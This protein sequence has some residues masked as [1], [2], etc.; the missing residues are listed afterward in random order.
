MSLVRSQHGPFLASAGRQDVLELVVP[1]GVSVGGRR[2]LEQA[3]VGAANETDAHDQGVSRVSRPIGHHNP[4]RVRRLAFRG[5]RHA[6]V[7]RAQPVHDDHRGGGQ[8]D[9]RRQASEN[10]TQPLCNTRWSQSHPHTEAWLQASHES[11]SEHAPGRAQPPG[12]QSRVG[13][14]ILSLRDQGAE[15]PKTSRRDL[16]LRQHVVLAGHPRQGE[17]GAQILSVSSGQR[18]SRGLERFLSLVH[19]GHKPRHGGGV[20]LQTQATAQ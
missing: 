17:L 5:D 13:A 19:G 16:A 18:P 8:G 1:I 11:S 14:L 7:H 15:C 6:V 3:N 20:T 12:A 10:R 4:H 9:N 2:G